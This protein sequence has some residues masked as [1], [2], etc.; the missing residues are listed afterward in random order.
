[1]T[2]PSSRTALFLMESEALA[3]EL[4]D[5]LG[6][7]APG[8]EV[9]LTRDVASAQGAAL[10]GG[11]DLAVLSPAPGV[12]I[13][14]LLAALARRDTPTILAGIGGESAEPG[15]ARRFVG[16]PYPFSADTIK[17]AIR[18]FAAGAILDVPPHA[19]CA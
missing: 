2:V 13:G 8:W 12:C 4:Q 7:L 18:A 3:L 15:R 9:M 16:I 6:A 10:F 17:T 11:L 1:V 5:L 19:S 14:P